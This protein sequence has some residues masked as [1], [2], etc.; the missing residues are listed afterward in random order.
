MDEIRA[1]FPALRQ[2]A[3]LNT[4][5]AGPL[6]AR[7]AA[8]A[9]QMLEDEA[10][11]GRHG[12]AY[13]GEL[14]RAAAR[15]REGIASL[16]HCASS[17]V[18]LTDGATS[19][20]GAV[21]SAYD[22]HAGDQVIVTDGEHAGGLAALLA[23]RLRHGIQIVTIPAA[24]DLVVDAFERCVSRRTR[25]LVVSH[26][27]W[28]RGEE[29]PIAELCSRARAHEVFS[30]IDGAQSFGAIDIDV[31]DLGADAFGVSGQKWL[32]GP[33][34]TGALYISDSAQANLVPAQPGYHAFELENGEVRW[35]PLPRQFESS[36]LSLP[37]LAALDVALNVA[38]E[39]GIAWIESRTSALA[40]L[41]RTELVSALPAESITTPT[42]R[43]G[44]SSF[45]FPGRDA[46]ELQRALAALGIVV[47]ATHEKYCLRVSTAYF[48]N[49][50]DLARLREALASVLSVR[51]ATWSA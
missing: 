25:M 37:L 12:D 32:C 9:R 20:M 47:R 30:L 43:S 21:V 28:Q 1:E 29:L 3:Y 24:P 39:R 7:A 38:I 27:T 35:A 22:W 15:C 4:G 26:V 11:F 8:I 40:F 14:T 10:A 23:V 50:D 33:E 48:N 19:A 5:S 41:C 31:V 42:A 45:R 6:S 44:L 18:A 13:F 34:G 36:G 51:G 46:R 16:L 49:D 17:Q 2:C